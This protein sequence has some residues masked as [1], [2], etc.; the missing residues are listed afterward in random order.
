MRASL[1]SLLSFQNFPK[2]VESQ[3]TDD[4]V[5]QAAGLSLGGR[6]KSVHVRCH[7][8]HLELLDFAD[9]RERK[10]VD[11]ADV[12][13]YLEVCNLYVHHQTA[14]LIVLRNKPFHNLI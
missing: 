1:I 3:V 5:I 10:L 14:W 9:D 8:P 11:E 7:L 13:R 2:C 6:L 4:D 12:V